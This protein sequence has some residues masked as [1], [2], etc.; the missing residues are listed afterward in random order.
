MLSLSEMFD[1]VIRQEI[2]PL[3]FTGEIAQIDDWVEKNTQS[4]EQILSEAARSE[5]AAAYDRTADHFDPAHRVLSEMA[6]CHRTKP[7]YRRMKG[8]ETISVDFGQMSVDPDLTSGDPRDAVDHSFAF[9]RAERVIVDFTFAQR[10]LEEDVLAPG[11]RI[12]ILQDYIPQFIFR[13]S[14]QLAVLRGNI[15]EINES[16]T[17]KYSILGLRR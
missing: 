2:P 17:L 3:Q 6:L 10:I 13:P 8:F 1:R 7:I 16:E 4:I 12:D 15:D 5:R 11:R 9:H 14:E